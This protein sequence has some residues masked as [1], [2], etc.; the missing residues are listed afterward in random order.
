M[1]EINA[2]SRSVMRER[3]S[4]VCVCVYACGVEIFT[5]V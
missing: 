2:F 1:R 3:D 5:R 4:T